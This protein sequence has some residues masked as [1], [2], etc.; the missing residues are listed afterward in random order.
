MF[1]SQTYDGGHSLPVVEAESLAH[2]VDYLILHPASLGSWGKC[3]MLFANKKVT[4]SI[5]LHPEVGR[6]LSPS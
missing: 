6:S 4:N 5:Y 2:I 3:K 1:Q